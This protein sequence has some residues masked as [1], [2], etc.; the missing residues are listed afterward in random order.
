M[1]KNYEWYIE[2]DA[3]KYAG[4]WIAIVDQ[5]VIVEGEDAKR[6]Y[7]EAK[8]KFPQKKPSLAKVP[9]KDTLVLSVK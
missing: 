6:V 4:K 8:E 7:N 1:S 9:M 2:T 3:S 5:K